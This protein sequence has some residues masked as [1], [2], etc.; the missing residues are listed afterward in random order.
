MPPD[1]LP[2]SSA[3]AGANE[4]SM[5]TLLDDPK[6][7]NPRPPRYSAAD[8]RTSLARRSGRLGD[9]LAAQD[10]VLTYLHEADE[11]D[12][13][14]EA[15]DVRVVIALHRAA[16]V[17]ALEDLDSDPGAEINSLFVV[18]MPGNLRSQDIAR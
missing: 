7:N 4:E 12:L 17:A 9:A 8:L 6:P 16:A 15:L 5:Q 18:G 11:L 2:A 1:R 10:A 3:I 13:Y 14:A